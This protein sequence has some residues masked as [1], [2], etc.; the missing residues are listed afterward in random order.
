MPINKENEECNIQI[1]GIVAFRNKMPY[2]II[3][4]DKGKGKQSEKFAQLSLKEARNVAH[5]ILTM[6]ARTEADAMIHKFFDRK[7]FPP[8]AGAELMLDF[9]NFRYE[10]DSEAIGTS[11]SEPIADKGKDNFEFR[12]KD[13]Q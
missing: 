6:C 2:I 5:D 8:M 4:K 12:K 13:V 10:I 11:V 1:E 9:R 7:E 3:Y